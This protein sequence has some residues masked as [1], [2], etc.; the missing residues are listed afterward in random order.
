MIRRRKNKVSE[1]AAE[2]L[3]ERTGLDNLDQAV[4]KLVRQVQIAEGEANALEDR[5]HGMQVLV[6]TAQVDL[7]RVTAD[8]RQIVDSILGLL[9]LDPE[10][11][12]VT[13]HSMLSRLGTLRRKAEIVDL[14]DRVRGGRFDP[15]KE[16]LRRVAC[17]VGT[18]TVGDTGAVLQRVNALAGMPGKISKLERALR[19]ERDRVE[20]LRDELDYGENSVAADEAAG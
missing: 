3:R 8:H 1:M 12:D 5:L 15:D 6:E 18:A 16:L 7:D 2:V 20:C 13:L 17:A 9:D 4:G 10:R 14:F 11:H 19:D